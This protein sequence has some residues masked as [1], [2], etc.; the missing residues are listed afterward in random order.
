MGAAGAMVAGPAVLPAIGFTK[1]GVAAG[2][3]AAAY[4]S[5]V[6]GGYIA[7]GSLFSLAQSA[8]A[9]G[10]GLGVKAFLAAAG[11]VMGAVGAF[12]AR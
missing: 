5:S 6:L 1:A 4:Q 9:A 7:S 3:L 8:G 10:V 2:S 11:G 12:A